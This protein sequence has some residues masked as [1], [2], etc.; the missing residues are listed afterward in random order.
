MAQVQARRLRAAIGPLQIAI[1]VL[2]CITA[3]VHL[4]RGIGMTFGGGSGGG[5]PGGFQG[6]PP[7]GGGQGGPPGGFQGGAPG[8][9]NIMQ[10]LPLPLPILFLLNGIGYLVLVTAL[11]LP[12]LQPY[13][14]TIRWL[15][16]IFAALTIIMYFLVVGF[17]SNPIGIIDKVV[18]VALIVLLVI[19]D[20]QSVR[21]TGEV[22]V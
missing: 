12:A 4:Q 22:G 6:G 8:G 19:E 2:V 1:I 20:R 3:L 13:R 16:I 17:S 5:P 21:A 9:F 11:Y 15:L 7:P 18:E 14:R 10:M